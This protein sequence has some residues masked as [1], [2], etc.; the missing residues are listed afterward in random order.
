MD[1]L[2]QIR[3]ILAESNQE[4][5]SIVEAVR[6]L[7]AEN[8]RLG[9][10]ADEGRQYRADLVEA[11]ITEGVRAM[12]E[13]FP[14]ETYRELLK[15]ASLEQV[16]LLRDRWQAQAAML[17]PGGRK[18]VDAEQQPQRQ[19]APRVPAAAHKC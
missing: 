12:G 9:P 10:L 7:V 4:F 18:T 8:A 3:A 5:T 6:G 1:E 15:S 19:A 13:A 17:F 2:E 11:A 14:T 16:K